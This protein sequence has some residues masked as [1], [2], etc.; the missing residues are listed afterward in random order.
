M[1]VELILLL[2]KDD[3]VS[4]FTLVVI[5]GAV[6]L[7]KFDNVSVVTLV[8]IF[9]AVEFWEQILHVLRQGWGFELTSKKINN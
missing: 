7:L 8:V 4:V 1:S 3:A 6:E 2:I 9:W 5:F